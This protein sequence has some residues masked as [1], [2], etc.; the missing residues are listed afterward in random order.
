MSSNKRAVSTSPPT[1]FPVQRTRHRYHR[2]HL[3]Y[4]QRLP[5]SPET[6]HQPFE[7][8]RLQSFRLQPTDG[9]QDLCGLFSKG[10]I[11]ISV[12][13]SKCWNKNLLIVA[14]QFEEV[15][16]MNENFHKNLK[17]FSILLCQIKYID[18]LSSKKNYQ[19]LYY[20]YLYDV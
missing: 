2:R 5:K 16:T 1:S 12:R 19:Y 11:C 15:F 8:H 3:Q 20:R 18:Y 14:A 7:R 6:Q 13:L 17:I 4:A 10:G 9:Q